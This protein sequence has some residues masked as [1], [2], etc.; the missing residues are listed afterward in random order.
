MAPQLQAS[1]YEF[2]YIV[3]EEMAASVRQFTM[4]QLDPDPYADPARGHRYDVHSAYLDNAELRLCRETLRGLKNRYKLRVR[5]YDALDD[6]PVFFEIKR[7][8]NDV[9][10]KERC[11]ADRE[12]AAR[13]LESGP[14]SEP[15]LLWGGAKD[16]KSL[17]RFCE[18]TWEIGARPQAVISYEREAYVTPHDNSVRV[19]FDRNIVCGRFEGVFHPPRPEAR[20]EDFAGGVVLELKFTN[21]FPAWM[22][23]MVQLFNLRR[24]S[25]GKYVE[26]VQT[27][28]PWREM[29]PSL[30]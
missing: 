13:M 29:G 14:N 22:R 16:E 11:A 15:E 1:R 17:R 30:R 9:I 28:S 19:T 23:E 18:H 3:T 12:S 7:R 5:F 26:G 2:K 8:M 10:M 21:R 4:T 6:S 24:N 27:L 25:M 20:S